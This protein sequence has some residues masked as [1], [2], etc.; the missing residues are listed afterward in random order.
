MKTRNKKKAENQFEST[1]RDL[2]PLDPQNLSEEEQ[3]HEDATDALLKCLQKQLK[4]KK[5]N[6]NS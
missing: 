6:P 3:A 1:V 2:Y 5:E 4:L